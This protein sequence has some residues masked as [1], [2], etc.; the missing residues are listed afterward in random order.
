M[1]F[2]RPLDD[3]S[4]AALKKRCCQTQERVYRDYANA[5]WTLGLR[6]SGCEAQ[7]WDAVQAGFVRAFERIGQLRDAS[8]FGPW[9]RRLIVNQ[10]MDQHR[11]AFTALPADHDAADESTA[12]EDR[13]DLEQALARLEP[14]DRAVLWLHDVEGLTHAEI[15]ELAGQ[16][17]SWSKS[18]LSRTRARVRAWLEPAETHPAEAGTA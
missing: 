7:A 9:L 13:L 10:V 11:R 5:A 3:L 18:R 16:S 14:L 4:L 6:L 8:A 17:A 15:A 12:P 2:S 1:D